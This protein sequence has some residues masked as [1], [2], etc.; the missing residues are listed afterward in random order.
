MP[1]AI[2]DNIRLWLIPILKTIV[3]VSSFFVSILYNFGD[4]EN[5]DDAVRRLVMFC[6]LGLLFD[7]A[8]EWWNTRRSLISYHLSIDDWWTVQYRTI[9]FCILIF[10]FLPMA[11]SVDLIH[12]IFFGCALGGL[13]IGVAHADIFLDYHKIPNPGY[14]T[15]VK[16]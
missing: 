5:D 14:E 16:I 7:L 1:I 2:K 4:I 11:F 13:K 10:S 9:P 3:W 8:L 12:M 15:P 6:T